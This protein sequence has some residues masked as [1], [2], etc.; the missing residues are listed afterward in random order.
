MMPFVSAELSKKMACFYL[1][2]LHPAGI[3]ARTYTI[4]K[5][6]ELGNVFRVF[7]HNGV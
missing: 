2:A 7:C 5:E 1:Q 3:L 4:D 6:D